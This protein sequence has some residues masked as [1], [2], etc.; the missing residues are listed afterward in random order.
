[1]HLSQSGRIVERCWQQLQQRFRPVSLD[2]FVVMPN[3]VHGIIVLHKDESLPSLS[4]VVGAFKTDASRRI[5]SARG[6]Y[7]V[8]VWQRS[9][10]DQIIRDDHH[11][12]T[13]R[14][15]INANPTNWPYD[16][17]NPLASK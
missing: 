3:H 8:P 7:G 2:G 11:L 15:Y 1:M 12:D 17:E 14:A 6:V 13:V 10:H 9:F 4:T 16:E 5:N